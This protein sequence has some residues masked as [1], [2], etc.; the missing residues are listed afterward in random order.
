ML[1]GSQGPELSLLLLS[2]VLLRRIVP[3][4]EAP[5]V[6]PFEADNTATMAVHLAAEEGHADAFRLLWSIISR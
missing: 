5:L 3:T 2:H 1:R 4:G 6:S